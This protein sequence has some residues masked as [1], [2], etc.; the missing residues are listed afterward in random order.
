MKLVY[1]AS[2]YTHPDLRVRIARFEAAALASAEIIKAGLNVFSPIVH[3]HPLTVHGLNGDWRT[4][5]EIDHDWIRRCDELWVLELHGWARSVGVKA[6]IEYATEIG[7]PVRHLHA[8][9]VAMRRAIRIYAAE[10]KANHGG[11]ESTDGARSGGCD[12]GN[13]SNPVALGLDSVPSVVKGS[14]SP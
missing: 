1:L 14:D 2:P 13:Q 11:T 5:Q 6:E 4:W 8:E 7:R 3:S 9:P 12:P 10:L